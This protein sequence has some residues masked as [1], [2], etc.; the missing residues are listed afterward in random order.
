MTSQ[1]ICI[2]SDQDVKKC[3][4]LMTLKGIRHLP[5]LEDGRLVGVVSLRDLVKTI[6][7]EQES[8]IRSFENYFEYRSDIPQ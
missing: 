7:A 8:K 2:D 4:A 5:V 6:I 3:M 1:V